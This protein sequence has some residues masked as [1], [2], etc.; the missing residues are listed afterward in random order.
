MAWR[1]DRIA[2]TALIFATFEFAQAPLASGKD[3]V[4]VAAPGRIEAKHDIMPLG[5]ATTGVV[6]DVLVSEGDRVRSGQ[7]LVRL[8]CQ[9][10]EHEIEVRKADLATA[11]AV[12][13]RTR[14]GSRNEEIAVASALVRLAEAKAEE[15][16]SSRKRIMALAERDVTSRARIAEAERDAR[17]TVA[18]LDQARERRALLIAGARPEEIAEAGARRDHAAAALEQ[19]KAQADLCTVR[20]PMDGVVLSTHVTAGQLISTTAPTTLLRLVDDRDLRVRAEVDERDLGRICEGQRATVKADG[21]PDTVLTATIARISPGMG[22]RTI[23]SGDPAEK[24][25]RDVREV[26]LSVEEGNVRWPIGLRVV[27]RFEA[28]SRSIASPLNLD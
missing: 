17:V 18:E 1:R 10:V 13:S 24:S 19:A 21:Y 9:V 5:S 3:A 15:A 22:R 11:D 23:L 8:D 27:V 25:D 2:W 28:C 26:L 14:S 7:V 6:Q 4:V 12:L 16:E 20:A